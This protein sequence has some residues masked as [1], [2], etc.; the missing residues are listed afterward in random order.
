MIIP[1]TDLTCQV[2][3]RYRSLHC[4][5]DQKDMGFRYPCKPSLSESGGVQVLVGSKGHGSVM[6][7]MPSLSESG[8]VQVLVGSKGHGS[9]SLGIPSPSASGPAHMSFGSKGHGS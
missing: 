4:V 5:L 3:H 8:G 6:S 7:G 9:V 1:I 2:C